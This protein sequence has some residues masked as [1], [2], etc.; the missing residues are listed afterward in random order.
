MCVCVC[1]QQHNVKI[2]VCLFIFEIKWP[3]GWLFGKT[4]AG[5]DCW[6]VNLGENWRK[7]YDVLASHS[8]EKILILARSLPRAPYLVRNEAPHK[9]IVDNVYPRVRVRVRVRVRERG[10]L[11]LIV[12]Y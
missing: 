5:P 12:R 6:L 3:V 8:M 1:V 4:F 11:R 7:T 2:V 9:H 10:L